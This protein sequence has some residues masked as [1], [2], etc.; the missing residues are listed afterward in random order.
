[1]NKSIL[2]PNY[3]HSILNLITSILKNYEVE[4]KYNTLEKIDKLLEK[5]YRNVVLVILDGMGE[6]IL[7]NISPNGIF[8]KNK[9]DEITSVYPSTT[10]AAMTT[11]Y[12]G[13]PPIE[14][15]WIAWSQ[16]FKEYGRNIDVLPERDSYTGEKLKV[17]NQKI[18]DI[19]GYKTVYEQIKE[20]NSNIET[21]EIMPSYCEKKQN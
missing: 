19:I 1:M 3:N 6:N 18:S 20:Q 7:K 4:T 9:I 5:K 14:T 11:Y 21:Y 15:G 10:T 16:Y 17:K 12:S 8:S 13:K 2:M